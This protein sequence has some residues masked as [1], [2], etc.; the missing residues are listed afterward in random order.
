[1]DLGVTGDGCSMGNRPGL[2]Q[3]RCRCLKWAM[4]PCSHTLTPFPVE[5]REGM[6]VLPAQHQPFIVCSAS[7][8]SPYTMLP[9]IL[10]FLLLP[11]AFPGRTPIGRSAFPGSYQALLFPG[12]ATLPVHLS[13]NEGGGA[14]AS[15]A[16]PRL[17]PR[18]LFCTAAC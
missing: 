16:F 17:L 18:N 14:V 5:S 2:L 3:L 8:S 4:P 12:P 11:C 6:P 1:M 15:R 9:K 10:A 13:R 7:Q